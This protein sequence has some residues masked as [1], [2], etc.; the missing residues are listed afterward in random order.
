MVEIEIAEK[1]AKTAKAAVNEAEHLAKEATAENTQDISE[2][3]VQ[4]TER[5]LK[6]VTNMAISAGSMGFHKA[7]EAVT[8]WG[9]SSVP[10]EN[11]ITEDIDI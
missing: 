8:E 6:Q 5:N 4:E 2:Q 1:A 11:D 7:S 3:A 9:S 10:K